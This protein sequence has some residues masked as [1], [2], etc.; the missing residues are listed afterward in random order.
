M[1]VRA[2]E[3]STSPRRNVAAPG[4]VPPGLN[5]GRHNEHSNAILPEQLDDTREAGVGSEAD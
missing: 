5:S 3:P 4:G 2:A 1:H